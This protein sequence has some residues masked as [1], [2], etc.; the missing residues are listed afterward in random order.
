PAAQIHMDR[1]RR[2]GS[3]AAQARGA[4][5]RFGQDRAG[6]GAAGI[7]GGRF[8]L[9]SRSQTRF[10]GRLVLVEA[11]SPR[12]AKP[13]AGGDVS[14]RLRERDSGGHQ[15][16]TIA[17]ISV[18]MIMAAIMIAIAIA[19]ITMVI[20]ITPEI[21]PVIAPLA[22]PMGVTP[23][24]IPMAVAPAKAFAA[25]PAEIHV[26]PAVPEM[27]AA[28]IPE[29]GLAVVPAVIMRT[30]HGDAVEHDGAGIDRI[31]AIAAIVISI[32][33][34]RAGRIIAGAVVIGG[35]GR[36]NADADMHAGNADAD[37]HLGVRGRRH[38]QPCRHQRGG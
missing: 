21:M 23:A 5:H 10:L 16:M 15:L 30:A 20:S 18:A 38:H 25:I 28:A 11:F 35:S 22:A 12:A 24:A 36:A 27:P 14:E 37:M 34:A 26:A 31:A 17:I 8:P 32:S 13:L 1:I 4:G 33:I 2:P 3:D 6:P 7:F 29:I 9:R 19:E